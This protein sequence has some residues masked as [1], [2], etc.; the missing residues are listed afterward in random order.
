VEF[1]LGILITKW[2]AEK[3]QWNAIN[4]STISLNLFWSAIS[5][6]IYLT[7]ILIN[8][9]IILL[10]IFSFIVKIFA[11]GFIA[12]KIYQKKYK[13]S[14]YFVAVILI[15]IFIITFLVFIIIQTIFLIIFVGL[16]IEL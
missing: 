13:R 15:G 16:Y 8:I 14:L 5:L 11:G 3:N 6:S 12:S 4:R 1:I 9:G 2:W 10:I 7:S